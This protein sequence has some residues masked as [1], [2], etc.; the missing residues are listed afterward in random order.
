LKLGGDNHD[1]KRKRRRNKQM[2]EGIDEFVFE[3]KKQIV[4]EMKESYGEK[5]Y[6]RWQ[7]QENMRSMKDPDGY[8]CL[9]GVCGDTMELFLKFEGEKVKEASFQTDGCGSSQVCCS[10]AAELALGK[11]PDELLEVTGETILEE[12]DGLPSDDTHCASLAAE[13]LQE[14]LN[15]Y[16]VKQT[17]K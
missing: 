12:L 15:A 3:L 5:T 8:A 1:T 2:E 6:Q 14:A 7:N 16:M 13:T 17:Q 11:S 4:A 9:K 10:M